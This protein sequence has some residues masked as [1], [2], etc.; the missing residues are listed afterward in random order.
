MWQSWYEHTITEMFPNCCCQTKN[1]IKCLVNLK[2]PLTRKRIVNVKW[3]FFLSVQISTLIG[4]VFSLRV[5]FRSFVF[6]GMS[7]LWKPKVVWESSVQKFSHR[8]KKVSTNIRS[9]YKLYRESHPHSLKIPKDSAVVLLQPLPLH[10]AYTLYYRTENW[11]Q[12]NLDCYFNW[13]LLYL[14][15]P[16]SNHNKF[17]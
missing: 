10:T 14:Y 7:Y 13:W 17:W 11:N 6:D 8:G 1:G 15:Q 12:E 2:F 5:K 4:S 3:F 16:L 9:K